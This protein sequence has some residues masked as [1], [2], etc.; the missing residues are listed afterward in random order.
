MRI[1]I[2]KMAALGVTT[3]LCIAPV[4]LAQTPTDAE[5]AQVRDLLGFGPATTRAVVDGSFRQQPQFGKYD[6]KEQSCLIGALTPEVDAELR[7]AFKTLFADSETTGAWLRF[8]RTAGG[9]KFT[10]L[11]RA[12]VDA[13]LK[14]V[15]APSPFSAIDQ[16]SKAE[17]ADI[18]AFMQSPAAAVLKKDFPDMPMPEA[19]GKR[20]AQ[21]CG[22]EW[23]EQ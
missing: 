13:K 9:D 7:N 4:A 1:R 15:A 14:G 18:S 8:G 21:R 16:M 19:F 6:A 20:A 3:M 22:I 5:I 17:Q 11:M 23:P 2:D 12:A 10:G